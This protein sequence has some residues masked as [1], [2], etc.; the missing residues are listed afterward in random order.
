MGKIIETKTNVVVKFIF[1]GN[2]PDDEIDLT[3]LVGDSESL[4]SIE[5]YKDYYW[6]KKAMQDSGGEIKN[7]VEGIFNKLIGKF[8]NARN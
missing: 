4:G 1:D 7:L 8:K 5:I 6:K 3:D 2:I